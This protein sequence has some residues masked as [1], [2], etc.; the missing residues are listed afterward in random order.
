MLSRSYSLV[1]LSLCPLL[2]FDQ[3]ELVGEEEEVS[4]KDVA[5][6]IVKALKFEGEYTVRPFIFLYTGILVHPSVV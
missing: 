1:G 6:A 4:I 3:T 5:D 2:I